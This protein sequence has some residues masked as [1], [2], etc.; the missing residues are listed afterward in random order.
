MKQ[1]GVACFATYNCGKY[2]GWYRPDAIMDWIYENSNYKHRHEDFAADYVE[3][4]KEKPKPKIVPKVKPKKQK[5]TLRPR[6][7]T[8]PKPTLKKPRS[9]VPTW[10]KV[11][12]KWVKVNPDGTLSKQTF[13]SKK[14]STTAKPTTSQQTRVKPTTA[15][16]ATRQ[17][18]TTRPTTVLP[19]TKAPSTVQPK[20][21]VAMTA[22]PSTRKTGSSTEL[23]S[24]KREIKNEMDEFEEYIERVATFM[25]KL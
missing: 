9:G 24:L 2:T 16:V 23:K 1:F 11:N 19:S 13:K 5:L 15:V 22:P 8:K 25:K 6:K 20:T 4:P 3:P 18:A 10:E 17:A 7:V 14:R 21:T 12:G